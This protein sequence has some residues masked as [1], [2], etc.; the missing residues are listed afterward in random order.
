MILPSSAAER[1]SPFIFQLPATSGRRAAACHPFA[2]V[3]TER[4]AE[5][6]QRR[7]R[8]ALRRCLI[9]LRG[10]VRGPYIPASSGR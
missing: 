1:R 5:R 6:L 7:A 10:Q 2:L 9:V 4:L 3:S 8:G